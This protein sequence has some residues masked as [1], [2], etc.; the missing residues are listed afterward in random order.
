MGDHM[1]WDTEYYEKPNI[2]GDAIRWE[3][4]C[5]GKPKIMK[6]HKAYLKN[7]KEKDSMQDYPRS[8]RG[9]PR[10]ER[11]GMIARAPASRVS[12]RFCARIST[13]ALNA[14]VG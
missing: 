10:S 5:Y 11:E 2:L 3:T 6:A 4:N 13:R 9:S 12:L 8:T 7:C 14:Q 1:V